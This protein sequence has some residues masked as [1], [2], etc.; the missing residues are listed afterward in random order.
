MSLGKSLISALLEG[1]S[2]SEFLGFGAID[3]LFK[4]NEVEVYSC[5]KQFV[6]EYG[7]LPSPDILLNH[8]GETLTKADGPPAYYRDLMQTRWEEIEVK[9]LM[10]KAQEALKP[11]GAGVEAVIAA[12]Q[13]ATLDFSLQ[14]NGHHFVDLRAAYDAIVTTYVSHSLPVLKPGLRLGWPYLDEMTGGLGK[15]DTV[16][17]VG[18]PGIGKTFQMLYAAHHGWAAAENDPEQPHGS[19]RLF[20]S[21]EMD[22]IP[23]EQR[24]IAMHT[25]MPLGDL[26]KGAMTSAHWHA[27]KKGMKKLSGYKAPFWIVDGNL[28][29]TVDDVRMLCRQL[30]PEAVFIDGAYLL[31]HATERDRYRRIAENA[32]LIK[33]MIANEVCPV[34]CSWQFAKTASK[35]KEGEEVTLDDIAYADAIAQVSSLVLGI[36]EEDDVETIKQR[37]IRVLKGRS[38]ETGDFKTHWNFQTMDFSQ[39]DDVTVEETK[40]V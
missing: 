28:T 18:R 35:K 3:H 23:I 40:F 17:L 32:E 26:K 5:L 8:T 38:G 7:K 6:T 24:L 15:G 25:H 30:K 16:A 29:A 2:V 21:M 34:V 33:K 31:K 36:F 14:R 1:G 13:K 27:T 11:G 4:G 22:I 37:R 39:A 9:R 12:M 10:Q 20:L 19:S